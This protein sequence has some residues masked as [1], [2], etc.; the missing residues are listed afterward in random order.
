LPVV[1]DSLNM[2]RS[3]DLT[4][5]ASDL[6]IQD[7]QNISLHL[8]ITIQK[9]TSNVQSV[10]RQ[11]IDIRL[12]LTAWQPAA[13]ARGTLDSHQRHLVSLILATLSWYVIET[14]SNVYVSFV[15]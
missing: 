5:P 9:V 10:P 6:L 7:D 1:N 3:S 14:V 12:N 13:R 11:S 2:W 4:Y 15:L 8:M